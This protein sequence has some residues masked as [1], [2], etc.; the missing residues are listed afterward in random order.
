MK[1]EQTELWVT[2]WSHNKK[3]I[4]II[5]IIIIIILL[6]S[7]SKDIF[8]I[9]RAGFEEKLSELTNQF[10]NARN[11]Y[12]SMC[13][14]FIVVVMIIKIFVSVIVSIIIIFALTKG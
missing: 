6:C 14:D 12:V 10:R 7:D 5:I 3:A 13:S 9:I 1:K 4:I 11:Y 8:I 2:I